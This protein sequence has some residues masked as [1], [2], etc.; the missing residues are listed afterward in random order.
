[1]FNRCKTKSARLSERERRTDGPSVFDW[2]IAMVSAAFIFCS[3]AYRDLIS[4][5]V[6]STN[7][8]DVVLDSNIRHLYELCSQNIYGVVHENMGSELMSVL[9]WS[10]W[11]LPIWAIQRFGGIRIV[12]SAWMLGW[13]KLFLVGMTALMLVYTY[14][15]CMLLTGSIT[16]SRWCVFLSG[17]SF[18]T[19]ISVLNAGQNDIVM[20]AASVMAIYYLLKGSDRRFYLFSV[21]AISI[22][23]FFLIVYVAVI[24]IS[25][26]NII[27]IL[28]KLLLSIS[29][30]VLQKA[31]FFNAP[32]Y[33]ESV[34]EGPGA[35]IIS[36]MFSQDLITGFGPVSLFA[37]GLVIIYFYAYTRKFERGDERFGKCVVYI[38]TMT[39]ICYLMFTTITY[40]RVL[41]LVPFIYLV[42]VQNE[43]LFGYNIIL[44]T[45]MNLSAMMFML[46]GDLP[47]FWTYWMEKSIIPVIIRHP[48]NLES[49]HN[50]PLSYL[51]ANFG[52]AVS[53]YPLFCTVAAVC[54]GL[55]LFLNSPNSDKRLPYE[56]SGYS[57]IL[58]TLRS[59][60]MLPAVLAMFLLA[61]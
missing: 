39:Y 49:I 40:Y 12:D 54:A 8:W 5:T 30:I 51:K 17:S 27:K 26:K 3:F 55:I 14:R 36:C 32:M 42:L 11:N 15:L 21:I 31:L 22:K 38:S 25:E 61:R 23:P 60:I 7:V 58:V 59:V 37:L 35:G 44:D 56:Y 46:L 48:I 19:F 43:R 50:G 45:A 10:I 47:P 52:M 6:W 34:N 41:L 33:A 16:K 28:L 57:R 2:I 9:P 4:L 29:G 20:I 53:F 18:Y 13:S 24:L 1:M